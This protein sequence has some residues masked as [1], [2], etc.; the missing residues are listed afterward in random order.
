MRSLSNERPCYIE[1]VGMNPNANDR[2]LNPVEGIGLRDYRSVGAVAVDHADLAESARRHGDNLGRQGLL[3]EA[4]DYYRLY[5]E[6]HDAVGAELDAIRVSIREVNPQ[7]RHFLDRYLATF[8]TP[9][10]L[11]NQV[12]L[13]LDMLAN[14][15]GNEGNLILLNFLGQHDSR[16][17]MQHQSERW[18]KEVNEEK[19]ARKKN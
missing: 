8:Y 19:L 7:F 10:Y 5:D 3:G 11:G 17:R 12:P 14:G 16:L 2:L 4:E 6:H 9:S 18:K 1:A 15:E 13:S